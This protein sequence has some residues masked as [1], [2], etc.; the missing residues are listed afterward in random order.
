MLRKWC[1]SSFLSNLHSS[2]AT[3]YTVVRMSFTTPPFRSFL[4]AVCGS[5]AQFPPAS[6]PEI[7]LAG[8][9]NVGK[10]S[11]PPHACS[12]LHSPSLR[13]DPSARPSRK[14][15]SLLQESRPFSMPWLRQLPP[16]KQ[17]HHPRPSPS[18]AQLPAEHRPSTSTA[19]APAA[20]ARSTRAARTTRLSGSWIFPDTVN[21]HP[22]L[23]PSL[24][25]LL[26]LLL[27]LIFPLN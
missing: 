7:A 6:L 22:S 23:P 19:R 14:A 25:L 10:N 11:H 12:P 26:L 3:A 5:A 4:L 15:D 13:H 8:R 17:A 27:L 20:R 2:S 9:S 1:S 18:A 21:S 24:L 16:L